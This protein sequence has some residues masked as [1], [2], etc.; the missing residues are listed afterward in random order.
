MI[1]AVKALRQSQ[2]TIL[3][4]PRSI[5]VLLF[6]VFFSSTQHNSSSKSLA[7]QTTIAC[8]QKLKAMRML[9]ILF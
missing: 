2:I 9:G 6:S 1:D 4:E 3:R 8:L 5:I 7:K